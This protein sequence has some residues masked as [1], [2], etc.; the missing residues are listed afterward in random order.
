MKLQHDGRL[1]ILEVIVV[2]H[3]IAQVDYRIIWNNGG[4]KGGIQP[5]FGGFF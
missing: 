1:E 3:K 2:A 5:D 4:F